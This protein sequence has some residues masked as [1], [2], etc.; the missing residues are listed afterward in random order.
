LKKAVPILSLPSKGS[1]TRV[2]KIRL[3]DSEMILKLLIFHSRNLKSQILKLIRRSRDLRGSLRTYK[4]TV[5]K[6]AQK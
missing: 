3:L 2:R 5:Q 1:W 4:K 6:L